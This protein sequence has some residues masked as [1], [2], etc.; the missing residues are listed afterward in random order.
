MSNA[1]FPT[2][3]GIAWPVKRKA[4]FNT[5]VLTAKTG[6]EFRASFTSYPTYTI[7]LSFEYLSL[8]DWKAL[9]GFFNLRRGRFDSFLF[10]DANDKS[11]VA[12]SFGTGN[13]T[14]TV[15][16]LVRTLGGFTEPCENINGT[17]SIYLNGVL[18]AS[19]YTISSTGVVTFSAA[20]ANTV[21]ITW[22][23]S[24]YWRV[25][26]EQDSSEFE[27]NMKHFFAN[28]KL[29]FIGSVGNKV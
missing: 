28:K 14:Q 2:F 26:F 21:A 5:K 16:Q 9:L 22:T 4:M 23:G 24:Y 12:Q 10:E 18:Q 17:P 6:R 1:V 25:R 7:D 8:T 29:A 3:A 20:P 27:E 11:V 19:G 15:F 13:G